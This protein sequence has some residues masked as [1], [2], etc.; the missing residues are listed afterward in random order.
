MDN[1]HWQE[2]IKLKEKLG[3]LHGNLANELG[4]SARA[5]TERLTGR[6]HVK[7]ETILA[8]RYLVAKNGI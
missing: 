7:R 4:I 8:M 1:E 6:A 5:L 2:F 3:L